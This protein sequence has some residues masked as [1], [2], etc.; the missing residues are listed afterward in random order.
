MQFIGL[1]GRHLIPEDKN[2]SNINLEFLPLEKIFIG[3]PLPQ[4]LQIAF[5]PE[6]HA[7]QIRG[8]K[9]EI[10]KEISL[11]GQTFMN[12]FQALKTE[13]DELKVDVSDLTTEQ[14]YELPSD[15]LNDGKYFFTDETALIEENIRFRQNARL[16]LREIASEYNDTDPVRIW[17]HHFDT[18]SI[19]HFEKD[20][21]GETI[22][23]IGI[24]FAIPD[25]MVPEPY[26]YLSYWSKNSTS[27]LEIP[28]NLPA[29][30]WMMP[31]WDGAVLPVSEIA[32]IKSANE[33]FDLVKAFFEAGIKKSIALLEID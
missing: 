17:P 6:S 19:I 10:I 13:L 1:S 16:V 28:Q 12:A 14:P 8:S 23:S 25:E 31:E 27:S 29:G 3:K 5:H 7:L 33:Q 18:G 4:G 15:S 26:F 22:K 11:E 32:R 20:Q 30:K 24:G 21:N 2:K 9:L